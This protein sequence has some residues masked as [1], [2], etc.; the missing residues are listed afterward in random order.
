MRPAPLVH[1]VD[2]D[3]A[4]RDALTLMFRSRGFRPRAYRSAEDC[5]AT[6]GPETTGCVV[7]DMRLPDMTGVELTRRLRASG[8]T[9]PVV[10]ITASAGASIAVEAMAAGASD[11]LEKPFDDEALLASVRRALTARRGEQEIDAETRAIVA[12]FGALSEEER[13]VLAG[14]AKGRPSRDIAQ[15]LGLE[16][17]TVELHRANIMAKANIGTLVELARLS[18]IAASAKTGVAAREPNPPLRRR[19]SNLRDVA[20]A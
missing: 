3:P 11:L 20:A 9:S 13:R 14:V 10:I 17:R 1:L 15:G 8:A 5:L 16:L 6:A 19:R 12:R 2:D 7:A 4:I 18:V